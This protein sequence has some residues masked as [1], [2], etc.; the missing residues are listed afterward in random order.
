LRSQPGNR[1]IHD[2]TQPHNGAVSEQLDRAAIRRM[3]Y[4]S[5]FACNSALSWS[6]AIIERLDLAKPLSVNA[7]SVISSCVHFAL[8][9]L[10][11][12]QTALT[13]LLSIIGEQ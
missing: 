13:R 9:D 1:T 10:E 6:S 5:Q 4:K 8:K 12:A 3:A 2:Q 7:N 11:N